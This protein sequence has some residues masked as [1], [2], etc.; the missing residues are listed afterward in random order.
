MEKT[1]LRFSWDTL[2]YKG[3]LAHS[4]SHVKLDFFGLWDTLP[5]G[6]LPPRFHL[7]STFF[8]PSSISPSPSL[9]PPPS[10]RLVSLSSGSPLSI[11]FGSIAAAV[12]MLRNNS[13]ALFLYLYLK[14]SGLDF[15]VRSQP[16][17]APAKTLWHLRAGRGGAPCLSRRPITAHGSVGCELQRLLTPWHRPAA[18]EKRKARGGSTKPPVLPSIAQVASR[19]RHCTVTQHTRSPCRCLICCRRAP[20]SAAHLP[21]VEVPACRHRASDSRWRAFEFPLRAAAGH[22]AAATKVSDRV[23]I[24]QS[25]E[26]RTSHRAGTPGLAR[27]THH[28]VYVSLAPQ[29]SNTASAP[30]APAARLA[31]PRAAAAR[32]SAP[33]RRRQ[34]VPRWRSA[35]APVHR[36]EGS[37][38]RCPEVLNAHLLLYALWRRGA[39]SPDHAVRLRPPHHGDEYH[40][41]DA[42]PWPC[43]T[44]GRHARRRCIPPP[45]SH[46]AAAHCPF[47]GA[48]EAAR[49]ASRTGARTI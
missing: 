7:A 21:C 20:T 28:H 9:L 39:R 8:A 22:P 26:D 16:A 38:L 18:R 37:A 40:T 12:F 4:V 45:P 49:R 13:R 36:D 41:R 47:V 10:P 31:L 14:L 23:L 44:S 48:P 1:W 46:M 3:P 11:V 33:K 19:N 24:D 6:S 27:A 5:A 35:Q 2:F 42:L 32:W 30:H 25:W 15:S 43:A 34:S 17:R 29:Q